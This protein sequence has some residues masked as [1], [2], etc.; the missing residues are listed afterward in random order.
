MCSGSVPAV[1]TYVRAWHVCL[2]RRSGR[3]P[4]W[5]ASTSSPTRSLPR[6]SPASP[7]AAPSP[8]AGLS[9]AHAA[10]V[11]NHGLLLPHPLLRAFPVFFATGASHHWW[12]DSF[13]P[14]FLSSPSAAG[15]SPDDV[16]WLALDFLRGR[17]GHDFAAVQD[18]CNG[19]VICFQVNRERESVEA[20]VCNPATRRWACLPRPATPWPPG[21]DGAFLA[22]DP[23]VSPEHMVFL[24]LVGLPRP[25]K[26]EFLDP[27]RESFGLWRPWTVT[28]DLFIPESSG[29]DELAPPE[30]KA[31]PV[32]VFSSADG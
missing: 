19:L 18:H 26:H 31:L 28:L 25:R 16:G 2:A 5:K 3:L 29:E 6:S 7:T 4:P 14:L 21:Y 1:H 32:R 20:Y 17:L 24:L 27:L 30:K 13:A 12:G 9:A 8:G 23:A 10:V 22:F 11:D 15:A